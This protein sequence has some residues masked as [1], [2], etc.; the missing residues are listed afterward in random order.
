[1]Q[2][3]VH[4]LGLRGEKNRLFEYS[5]R[6]QKDTEKRGSGGE[7]SKGKTENAAKH[8]RTLKKVED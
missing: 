6:E 2:K 8:A 5:V 7:I 1:M 4:A 3:S